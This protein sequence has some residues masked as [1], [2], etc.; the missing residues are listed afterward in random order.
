MT[1]NVSKPAI[2]VREKLAELDK[3]TGIAGEAMLR[4]ETPQE[5]FNLIGAGRR[6][7]II[8]GDLQ[9]AQRGTSFSNPNAVYTLDR[10]VAR[11]GTSG[12]LT[13]SQESMDYGQ[14][15]V[16]N[17]QNFVR[18][19]QT[20]ARTGAYS[21]F[22]QRVEDVTRFDN[23]EVTISFYAKCD[24]NKEIELT[25]YQDFGTSGST[26]VVVEDT[27]FSISTSWKRFEITMHC[28]SISGKT[29]NAGSHLLVE[30]RDETLGTFRLD[31]TGIQLEYG[32]VATPFEHRSYGEELALC[33]RY[34]QKF[35]QDVNASSFGLG[36]GESTTQ[37]R[38]P[39]TFFQ[40]M[41]A[42]P[43]I[44]TSTVSSW[45]LVNGTQALTPTAISGQSIGKS[46]ALLY[47]TVSGA[48]AHRV[49]Y[50]RANSGNYIA[51]DAEL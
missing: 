15:D 13:V 2:N 36:Y 28:P 3:P 23:T 26:D 41:R 46:Y 25:V 8:N 20:T 45:E 11:A 21:F 16:P 9:V 38:L 1:V 44:S 30:F 12:A 18:L 22:W 10:F 35:N 48:V 14:T 51:L 17:I 29:V 49:Y 7:M 39:F 27:V 4:A 24:K 33:Q 6:N 43:S 5:Q 47:V 34:Y 31:I 40:T 42:S 19:D 50:P 32:R 37:I